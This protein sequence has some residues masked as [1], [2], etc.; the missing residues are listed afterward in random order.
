MAQRKLAGTPLDFGTL[1]TDLG[2]PGE[3]SSAAI[4][5]AR[6]A[7]AAPV[8]PDLDRTDIEFITVDP[9][10]SKDLDQALHI[11]SAG[12]GYLV[13][14]AIAD[15]ASFV[16]PGSVLDT[17]VRQRGETYYFPDA[18]VP[19]HPPVLSEG[20]ASLLPNQ[21]VPAVL[22]QIEL[23]AQGKATA[24]EVQRA[25][26]KSRQQWDYVSLQKAIEDGNGP[27]AVQLLPTV[28]A[29]RQR[30]ARDRHA[31]SLDLPEQQVVERDDGSW[32]L[33]LRAPLPIED[34]NSEISL[35][36][37]MVAAQLMLDGGIGIIRTLPPPDAGV[38][39]ALRRVAPG[40]GIRWPDGMP[41]GDLIATLNPAN[42]KHA[43]FID[44]AASLLRGAAYTSFDGTL[45]AQREHA[46][47]G[48]SYA[49]VTA[50]LRRLVDR[51]ASEVCL[52]LHAEQVVPNWVRDALPELPKL[53]DAADRLAHQ[54][55]RAVVDATEAFLLAD[56]IGDRFNAVVLAADDKGGT[57]AIEDPAVRARCAGTHLQV[58]EQLTVTL[59]TADVATRTV[60]FVA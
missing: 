13:C 30:L 49:H 12:D 41:P 45:P 46:G 60:S 33:T 10:G 9:A 23:D 29:L 3:F 52:A 44:H 37:G 31:V 6:R 54:S 7:A 17:E 1:R 22:W 2:V 32:S 38:V 11:A 26:V 4:G 19:L 47:I 55:D 43:A 35:L 56:R 51:F 42:G 21:V 48:A 36:T 8:L 27:A 57:I 50:P 28:G 39:N 5:D 15:V 20:A 34:A 58:G 14:Y 59:R 18:R 16:R 25:R 24:V 53:M 40:L